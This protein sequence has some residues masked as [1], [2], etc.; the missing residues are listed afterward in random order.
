[1]YRKKAFGWKKNLSFFPSPAPCAPTLLLFTLLSLCCCAFAQEIFLS[2]LDNRLYRLNLE[3]CSYEQAGLMPGSSTD[4]SF[5]PNGNLYSVNS[6]GRIFQVDPATG[7]GTLLH[8]FESS[9]SQLYTSLTIDANGIFYAC[10]L[11]GQLWSYNLATNT[12]AYLGDVGYPAE[13]DLAFHNGQLYMAAAGDNIVRVDLDNPANSSIA[14]YGSVPGR[15][16]GIVSYAAACD[17]ISTYALTDNAANV[18]LIDF[19]NAALSLYCSIPL[20]VSG[21]ASTFEFW[22]SNPVDIQEVEALGFSCGSNTGT[23]TVSASGGIGQLMYSLDGETYQPGPTFSNLALDTYRVYVQD[24][25]GCI[26]DEAVDF[27]ADV[28]AITNIAATPASCGEDNGRFALTVAGGEPPYALSV[29]G[30]AAVSDLSLSGLAPGTYQLEVLDAQGC[31]VAAQATIDDAGAPA[32][33]ALDIG[34]TTCGE[35]NGSLS[36][37]VQGG[38]PPL[39]FAL[40]GGTPQPSGIF[41]SLPAGQYSLAVSDAN[42]CT[43]TEMAAVPSSEAVLLERVER[44]NASCGEANGSMAIIASAGQPP[45]MYALDGNSFAADNTFRNLA[46][47]DYEA[48]VMDAAG[49]RAA[50]Q[51]RIHGSE[52]PQITNYT[53]QSADCKQAN[54]LIALTYQ[55]GLGPLSLSSNGKPQPL[56]EPLQ[57]LSAGMYTLRL[58]DSLACSDTLTLAVPRSNCPVYLPNAF[59]PNGDGVNDTFH[60]QSTAGLDAQ[61]SSFLVYNRWGGEV[62]RSRNRPFSDPANAW[63]GTQNGKPLPPDVFTYY[64][65]VRFEDGGVHRA[66]GDVLLAR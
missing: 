20:A 46:S 48:V 62:F 25:V 52:P 66:S 53:I 50:M 38:A 5:H 32:I 23:I 39:A 31:R 51:V 19:E 10:G 64:L 63:D 17:S 60:P 33:R 27:P 59:S 55:G 1:M 3:D 21:G 24:E 45:L 37:S 47:G 40:N 28:P 30:S 34:P 22:G 2:T 58:V 41:A 26:V 12:G 42:N 43:L 56:G 11:E 8:V 14:V 36:L 18:Y 15:I 65:E 4:I 13:G 16:F 6:S 54:G 29:D 61:I 49:C 7:T 57:D 9:P 35:G 44:E